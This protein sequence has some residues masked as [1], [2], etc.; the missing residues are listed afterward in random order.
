L[1]RSEKQASLRFGDQERDLAAA[2]ADQRFGRLFCFPGL[3]LS[4]NLALL[5]AW[6]DF[7][8]RAFRDEFKDG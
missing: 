1:R 2:I 3:P 4:C 6:L 5:A 7:R 8:G